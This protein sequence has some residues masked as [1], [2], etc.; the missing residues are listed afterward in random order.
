[1]RSQIPDTFTDPYFVGNYVTKTI[2][3]EDNDDFNISSGDTLTWTPYQDQSHPHRAQYQADL[4]TPN[5]DWS[6]TTTLPEI[7]SSSDPSAVW[8]IDTSYQ[9]FMEVSFLVDSDDYPRWVDTVSAQGQKQQNLIK[10]SNVSENGD[11]VVSGTNV[12]A[13]DPTEFVDSENKHSF[14]LTYNGNPV[15][16]YFL[17]S[18]RNKYQ[19]C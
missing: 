16:I 19:S 14:R 4:T 12:Y 5:T 9:N 17:S 13:M 7:M 11:N 8:P 2:A 18:D 10:I 6:V 15:R 1:M 3:Q